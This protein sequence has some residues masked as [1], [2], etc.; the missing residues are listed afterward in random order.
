MSDTYNLEPYQR[1]LYFQELM[2]G[3]SEQL[4]P[5][6]IY[7]PKLSIDGN[8]W[9]VL[10]GTNLHDGVAGFGASPEKAMIAFD[11]EWVKDLKRKETENA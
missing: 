10:Y 5:S 8:Q 3:V 2:L 4:R 9:C 6:V 1:E 7:R 11:K